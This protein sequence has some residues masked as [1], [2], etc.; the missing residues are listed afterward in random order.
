PLPGPHTPADGLSI[1]GLLSLGGCAELRSSLPPELSAATLAALIDLGHL[2]ARAPDEPVPVRADF[3]V[4]TEALAVGVRD[5]RVQNSAGRIRP[6]VLDPDLQ[7]HLQLLVIL[8]GLNVSAPAIVGS[9][10]RLGSVPVL[11]G[12][13]PAHSSRSWRLPTAA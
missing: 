7:E 1:S 13:A 11:I 4:Q 12:S 9:V 3:L 5:I 2:V 6:S 10:P 8:F